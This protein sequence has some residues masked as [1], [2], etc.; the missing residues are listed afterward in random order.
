MRYGY[1]ALI[2]V[3]FYGYFAL[4]PVLFSALDPII[5]KFYI[6]DPVKLQELSQNAIQKHGGPGG[7]T[8]LLFEDLVENLRLEYGDK[9]VNK[10][11]K[12][13]WFFK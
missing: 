6:F 5:T 13:Q 2:P 1:L 4:L 8:T 7:N 10:L 3:L 12:D 11:S 9:Y